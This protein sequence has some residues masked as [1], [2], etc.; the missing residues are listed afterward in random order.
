MNTSRATARARSRR[1]AGHLRWLANVETIGVV[2]SPVDLAHGAVDASL[3]DHRTGEPS[4]DLDPLPV[5]RRS[6]R[7]LLT[8]DEEGLL[9]TPW[10]AAARVGCSPELIDDAVRRGEIR[11]VDRR[12]LDHWR[13]FRPIVRSVD[14]DVWLAQSGG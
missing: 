5:I 1:R 12:K 14:V 11:A 4:S 2:R 10:I 3:A 9:E 6:E 13:A 7:L 8:A